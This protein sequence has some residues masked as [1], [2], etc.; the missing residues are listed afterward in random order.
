MKNGRSVHLSES[1]SRVI[2]E[3]QHRADFVLKELAT[4]CSLPEYTVRRTLEALRKRGIL[5]TRCHFLDL[6]RVGMIGGSIYLSVA[7]RALKDEKS[8]LEP[9]KQSP[10]ITYIAKIDGPFNYL[11]AFMAESIRPV[12]K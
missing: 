2:A 6:Y 9:L 5:L 7:D 12:Q 1:E 10:H 11:I 8:F 3:C 4:I